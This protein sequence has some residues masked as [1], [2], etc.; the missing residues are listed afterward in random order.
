MT[1]TKF[2]SVV[3][4]LVARNVQTPVA[5]EN[6]SNSEGA[7]F[8]IYDV[9]G[10]KPL[11]EV[12]Y[13]M[14]R[15]IKIPIFVMTSS[16]KDEKLFG[17]ASRLIKAGA[18]GLVISLNEL[19][20]LNDDVLNKM[21]ES[22]ILSNKRQQQEKLPYLGDKLRTNDASNGSVVKKGV[23]GFVNLEDKVQQLMETERSV[24]TEAIDVIQRA[25]PLVIF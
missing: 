19:K 25:A 21:F 9:D 23:V 18:S 16:F 20:L 2:E 14:F 4:P 17:E 6:A 12:V 24:L 8:L 15:R 5:A 3:L 1:D 7:D 10:I 13:T 11:D 22:V